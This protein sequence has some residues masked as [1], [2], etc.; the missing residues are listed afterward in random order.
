MT[1]IGFIGLI[2]I[3]KEKKHCINV[4][5]M[6]NTILSGVLIAFLILNIILPH[7]QNPFDFRN[8]FGC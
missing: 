1:I 7:Y 6:F 5:T 2:G 3:W 4:Y 8:I